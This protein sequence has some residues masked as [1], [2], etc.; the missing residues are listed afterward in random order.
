V[1]GGPSPSG[2]GLGPASVPTRLDAGHCRRDGRW[3]AA[4]GGG[5]LGDRADGQEA[6]RGRR[7]G[8]GRWAGGSGAT[9]LEAGGGGAVLFSRFKSGAARTR[10]RGRGKGRQV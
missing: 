10:A 9:C 6:R 4:K 8:S 5:L 2:G 7:A 1:F 3:A